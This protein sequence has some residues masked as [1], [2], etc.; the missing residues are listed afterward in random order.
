MKP[1]ITQD[2][3]YEL[4]EPQIERLYQWRLKKPG[5]HSGPYMSIAE[6]IEFLDELGDNW[7][8]FEIKREMEEDEEGVLVKVGWSVEVSYGKI[9]TQASELCDALWEAVKL[10]LGTEAG[11]VGQ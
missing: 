7:R 5:E 8:G 2:R 6:M 3:V 9:S 10:L 1:Y 11:N 4:S